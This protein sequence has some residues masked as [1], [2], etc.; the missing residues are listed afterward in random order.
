MNRL[1]CLAFAVITVPAAAAPKKAHENPDKALINKVQQQ[2]VGSLKDP[3]SARFQGVHVKWGT[4][5]GEVN[6]KN[7]FGG[8]TG[9]KRFLS[10]DGDVLRMEGGDYFADG[11]ETYC[12]ARAK[13]PS[14]AERFHEEA[15]EALAK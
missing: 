5:C 12:S 14:P 15:R 4:V 6:A 10:I 3:E 9:F 8:Y 2:V 11:W 7:S 13:M 1:L